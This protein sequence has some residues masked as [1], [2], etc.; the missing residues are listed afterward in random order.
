MTDALVDSNVILDIF[1]QDQTW[2]PWSSQALTEAHEKGRLIINPVIYAEVSIH[3]SR[4]EELNAAL[5]PD[6]FKR[7]PIPFDAAF[8]AG[9]AYVQYR[10]DGGQ[11]HFPLPDFFIGAHAAVAGYRLIT[12]DA[13]RFRSY[14]PTLTVIAPP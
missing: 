10:R 4:I 7:E 8:L 1:T 13:A 12:R 2:E 3:F 5:P 9:K 11:R 14:F 6:R